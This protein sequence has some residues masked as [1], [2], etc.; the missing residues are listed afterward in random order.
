MA[1][2]GNDAEQLR[3][4]G[5]KNTRCRENILQI[6]EHSERPLTA[7]EIFLEV[8]RSGEDACLSTVYRSLEA[9]AAKD[10]VR[11]AA[12]AENGSAMFELNRNV[13]RHYLI[14][15]NCH[16]MIPVENCP[17]GELEKSLEKETGFSVTGH[18]LEIYGYCAECRKQ[19]AEN[20]ESKP[21]N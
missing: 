5:L 6:L 12:S 1:K 11:K 15:L 2:T 4:C 13:H 18:S 9:L 16:H 8:K 7:E 17:L 19:L 14:C 20:K 3:R 10:V 21:K